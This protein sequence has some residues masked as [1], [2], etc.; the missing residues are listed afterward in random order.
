MWVEW[1]GR[2]FQREV[3]PAYG[4][5]KTN[6]GTQIFFLRPHWLVDHFVFRAWGGGVIFICYRFIGISTLVFTRFDIE[7]FGASRRNEWVCTLWKQNM[8]SC[9]PA[10]VFGE[11]VSS[12]LQFFLGG[13][14]LLI[15]WYRSLW[16]LI[17]H[18]YA[19]N[20]NLIIVPRL[21][22]FV[23]CQDY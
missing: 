1:A 20:M 14:P 17:T 9:P 22:V 21:V 23:V 8:D 15:F 16:A 19:H 3:L 2:N 11:W 10:R 13:F 6:S 18:W 12:V 4:L 7:L 5:W